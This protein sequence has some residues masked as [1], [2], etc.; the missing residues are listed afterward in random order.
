MTFRDDELSHYA[1]FGAPALPP[2]QRELR[3]EHAGAWIWC[4]IYGDGEPVLLLHGAFNH[5]G[6]WAHQI[7]ALVEAGYCAIAVDNRGRGRSTLGGEALGYGLLAEEVLAVMDAIGLPHAAI[8]GWS[9]GAIIALTMAMKHPQRVSRVFAFGTVMHLSGLKPLDPDDPLLPRVFE[10]VKLDHAKYS[11][12]ADRFD[13]IAQAVDRMTQTQPTYSDTELAA[14][15]TPVA[16]VSGERDEFIAREHT[17]HLARVIPGAT[18]VL[19]PGVSHFALLQRPDA[20]NRAMLAF[21]KN[22][23]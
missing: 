9:D 16:I 23:A 14:I 7:M 22:K 5:G 15:R 8:V 3:V 1:A 4:G 18:P 13:A 17:E 6:D 20:F 10:R 11:P 2:P 21:L 12:E 19:L